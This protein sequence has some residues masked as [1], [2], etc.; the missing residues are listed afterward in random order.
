MFKKISFPS[1]AHYSEASRDAAK[2][3]KFR[4]FVN[5]FFDAQ[6]N[7]K[8]KIYRRFVQNIEYLIA[9][10]IRLL[11]SWKHQIILQRSGIWG[12]CATLC[13]ECSYKIIK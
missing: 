7:M 9:L 3:V 13:K 12:K 11:A 4:S 1:N 10:S 5:P 2:L 8:V 6:Q